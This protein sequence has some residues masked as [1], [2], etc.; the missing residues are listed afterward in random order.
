MNVDELGRSITQAVRFLRQ[1][2]QDVAQLLTALDGLM[3]E[4]QWQPT[5]RSRS[6]RPGKWILKDQSRWYVPTGSLAQFQTLIAFV[7]R[8]DRYEP[9]SIFDWP[10]VLGVT[11]LFPLPMTYDAVLR[12]WKTVDPVVEGLGAAP[13]PRR[14]TKEEVD[15]ILPTSSH[16]A[17]LV[18]PLCEV[19]GTDQLQSR[20][21]APVLALEQEQR[22]QEGESKLA[23]AHRQFL[24]SS[25]GTQSAPDLTINDLCQQYS[26]PPER[27][28]AILNAVWTEWQRDRKV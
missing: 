19:T 25:S 14:L 7:I 16:A 6:M 26:I 9:P 10:V 18:V 4:R 23:Q 2:N 15:L 12:Q 3:A 8:Y 20:C 27:A 28:A 1:V 21:V 13:G 5:E 22:R 11:A 17:G 24:N